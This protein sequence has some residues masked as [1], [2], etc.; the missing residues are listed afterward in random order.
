MQ[1]PFNY[2]ENNKD[3]WE[4]SLMSTGRF[5]ALV[6][7]CSLG[8]GV[9]A[10]LAAAPALAQDGL[11]ATFPINYIPAAKAAAADLPPDDTRILGGEPAAPGAWPWQVALI[12]V[13]EDPFQGQFCGGSIIAST[14]ILTAAHCVY[15][16]A[17]DHSLSQTRPAEIQVL[18]GTNVL[19]VG[20][21]EFID[22]TG[23]YPHPDYDP[24]LIDNDIALIRLAHAPT[25]PDVAFVRLPTLAAE[26]EYAPAGGTAIVTGWGRLQNGRFPEDLMQVQI[27]MLARE[28]CNQSAVGDA[29]P[30]PGVIVTGPITDNMI[31][32][33]VQGGKGSCNGD[34]GGPLVVM[35]ADRSYLQVGIVSWG[36]TADNAAGCALDATFD[37][38]TRIARYQ[39]WITD[40]IAGA[41]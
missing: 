18:V 30:K 25:D 21:G 40:T 17:P 8:M 27:Q 23:I 11:T 22:V 1:A 15:D 13:G 31:C 9:A 28:D 4:G 38:Y 10:A 12:S 16:E 39:D 7:V 37:A 32:A 24:T 19:A 26:A 35:L 29:P 33:L 3:S 36:Y 2:D 20:D 34:S 14:W 41:N 6:G 5:R